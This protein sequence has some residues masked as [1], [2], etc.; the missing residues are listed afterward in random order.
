M[1]SKTKPNYMMIAIVVIVM[2]IVTY[3]IWKYL[4]SP[5]TDDNKDT[6]KETYNEPKK[7]LAMHFTVVNELN[8]RFDVYPDHIMLDIAGSSSPEKILEGSYNL[9]TKLHLIRYVDKAALASI[10]SCQASSDHWPKFIAIAAYNDGRHVRKLR[11]DSNKISYMLIVI[12]STSSTENQFA[13]LSKD[14]SKDTKTLTLTSSGIIKNLHYND[15]KLITYQYKDVCNTDSIIDNYLWK[16]YKVASNRM[17]QMLFSSTVYNPS[18]IM[19]K[20]LVHQL[21]RPE[22][23]Y[24]HNT[25][26]TTETKITKNSLVQF[27]GSG[28]CKPAHLEVELTLTTL[29]NKEEILRDKEEEEEIRKLKESVQKGIDKQVLAALKVYEIL[30]TDPKTRT[31]ENIELNERCN[32]SG[33][34]YE[35]ICEDESLRSKFTNAKCE[36]MGL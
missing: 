8:L 7:K 19:C 29:R 5:K 12:P 13:I 20:E 18:M 10:V 6:Y 24:C 16:E 27:F 34:T 3:G 33:Y 11:Y 31:D 32:K 25:N 30:C 4:S 28:N 26:E 14:T 2:A 15:R 23:L 36:E 35:K 21:E 9:D 17:E 1:K 22:T